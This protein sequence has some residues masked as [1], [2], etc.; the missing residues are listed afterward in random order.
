MLPYSCLEL[1]LAQGQQSKS[2]CAAT[3]MMEMCFLLGRTGPGTPGMGSPVICP[4]LC[5]LRQ[6]AS[7]LQRGSS[8]FDVLPAC[9]GSFVLLK[10]GGEGGAGCAEGWC[11]GAVA[12]LVSRA[13]SCIWA[14]GKGENEEQM[15]EPNCE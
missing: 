10:L 6:G 13:G 5:F 15:G 7:V 2:R 11:S 12:A 8:P 4:R 3:T 1:R 14:G 9:L